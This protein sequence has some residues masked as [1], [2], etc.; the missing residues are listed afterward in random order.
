[1]NIFLLDLI[2]LLMTQTESAR[3]PM[4]MLIAP[5]WLRTVQNHLRQRL[6]VAAECLGA[7]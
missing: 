2:L 7:C 3:R 1:L 6:G 4:S 5:A